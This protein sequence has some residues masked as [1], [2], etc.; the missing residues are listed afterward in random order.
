MSRETKRGYC[1]RLRRLDMPV[2][3]NFNTH[4]VVWWAEDQHGVCL[5]VLSNGESFAVRESEAEVTELMGG[6]REA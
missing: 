1:I 4:H 2:A 5:V 3:L 6:V